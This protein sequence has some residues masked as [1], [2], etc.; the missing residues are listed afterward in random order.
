MATT[1]FWPVKG[2]LKKAIDYAENPDK[3][4]EHKYL[5]D[6][7]YRALHYVDN[8]SKTD[9]KMY[10]SAIN[11]P[12]QRAYETMMNTKRRFGKMGGNVAYHGY[13]SFTANEVT[14]E[15]A[16][17]IGMETAKRMWGDEYQIVV[18]THLNTD[19]IHNHMVLNSVS[20]KT[21]RKFEN[22]IRDH[23]RLR[24]ISD[25]VCREY[26]K[27]VL[28]D[29][30]FYGKSKKEYWIQQS[31]G[32]SRR[33]VLK[34]DVEHCLSLSGSPREFEERL[35]AQGY[36]II[37][38][39]EEY[40]Y[41]SVMALGWQRPIRLSSI[42]YSNEVLNERMR[43]NMLDDDAFYRKIGA[44]L[45]KPRHTPL[46]DFEREYRKAMR[47][48]SVQLTFALIVALLRWATGTPEQQKKQKP[49]SPAM[50]QEVAK[51]EQ[52][53]KQLRLL[54]SH[55]IH[56]GEELV[57]FLSNT[58]EQIKT[59]EA[60]RQQLRNK[61]RRVKSPEEE[62]ELK[63]ACK[64]LSTKLKPLRDQKRTAEKIIENTPKLQ[65]LL[66]TER[67]MEQAV[68]IREQYKRRERSI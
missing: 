11:C 37:R 42:G 8:D 19:N 9:Q 21:G 38:S 28:E 48:D 39:G 13:Q 62:Q 20:F 64:E 27:E 53:A 45:E 60:Q 31:G 23:I 30:S 58:E 25:E 29:A 51:M 54:S 68:W 41:I 16:H 4:T 18:T 32:L 55:D 40:K 56:T 52:Y 10:V 67:Q 12:K 3:T 44:P 7:L 24:E 49:L 15:E 35:K 59:L 5:D 65:E 66:E 26:G 17:R 36:Q 47:M 34:Q 43:F 57:S 61:L 6:D 14:P 46:M 50:R 2:S 22:H 63:T 1:G 33:D